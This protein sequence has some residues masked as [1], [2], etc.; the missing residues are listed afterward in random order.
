[1]MI[2]NM[3]KSLIEHE[4]IETTIPKAKALRKYA[5]HL[6]TLALKGDLASL[7]KAKA[8][9]KI[10]FNTLS[11]KEKKLAKKGDISAYNTDRRILKKLFSDW[12]NRFAEKKNG[13]YT[14]IIKQSSFRIGDGTYKCFIELIGG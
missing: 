11:V 10:K 12:K 9:L 14:R 8:I 2:S 6:I 1:M 5:D 3:L 7:R 13:G 4:R